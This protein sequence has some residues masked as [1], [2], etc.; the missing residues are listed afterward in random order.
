MVQLS[1]NQPKPNG[2]FNEGAVAG[3]EKFWKHLF[4]MEGVSQKSIRGFVRTT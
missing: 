3:K 4:L 1:A 2:S